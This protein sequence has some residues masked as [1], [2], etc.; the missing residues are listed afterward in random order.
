MADP[1]G[2]MRYPRVGPARRPVEVRLR[3][4]RE[5]YNP[6]AKEDLTKQAARCMDCGIP[7][8]HEGC[9]LGNL[10]PEWNDLVFRG[11]F[12]EASSRLHATNNFPE[13][14]G[15]LCP[16]PCEGSCVLGISAEPVAIKQVEVEIAEWAAGEGFTPVLPDLLHDQRVA[17]IGS[18]PAGLA[19]AQQ[20]TRSGYHVE[21]FER[22]ER[23]GGLLRYGVPEFK[24]EKRVID[25]RLA[26]MV[27]EGTVFHTRVA[28]GAGSRHEVSAA[29][30]PDA[31]IMPLE[32]LRSRFDAIV[33]AVG[34]TRP[35]DLAVPG[36]DLGGI[37]FAMD[38][39]KASNLYVEG[40][41]TGTPITAKDKHV[42]IIGGGDTGA[43]CLGTV[44]RQGA[45]SVAQLEI[46]PEPPNMRLGNNPWPTW[47]LILRSSAAHEEGGDRLYSIS[48]T[49]FLGNSEGNVTA[50][51]VATVE[52]D[53]SG[54]FLPVAESEM[55]LPA[56]LVLLALGFT[57]P[58]HNGVVRDLGCGLTPRGNLEIDRS[59]MTTVPGV[60]AC[61]DAA[62]GQ[63]LVVWAIAEGRSAARAV[64]H[65]LSGASELPAPIVPG[66]VALA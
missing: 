40:T 45:S 15:R 26:Q 61:G 28:V 13:F 47:P 6:F 53:S 56:D 57:G 34:S 54:S 2:F 48:T 37:H 12:E 29:A 43:D 4:W 66:Q 14:T 49:Q 8:C 1:R 52:R 59:F 60:F 25:R 3:D 55:D 36:R 22:A 65:F 44:H 5:V 9:P 51:Q 62:R 24:L 32:E 63:S 7:F 16:A 17:V 33:L 23:I 21:V 64:D 19:V 11:R 41:K 30:A 18:G 46:L 58:E 10:I 35:R 39:L 31:T 50:L 38:Y 27:A 20:L 42:V